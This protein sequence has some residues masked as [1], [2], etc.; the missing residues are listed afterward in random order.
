[1]TGA[2]NFFFEK[3]Q[4]PPSHIPQEAVE[5]IKRVRPGRRKTKI[6]DE[7]VVR[8]NSVQMRDMVVSYAPSGG[9]KMAVLITLRV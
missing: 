5:E 1:M 3:L 7:V 2:F 6:T 4:I 9:K 8:F